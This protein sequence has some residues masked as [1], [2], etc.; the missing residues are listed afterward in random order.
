MAS[1]LLVWAMIVYFIVGYYSHEVSGGSAGIAPLFALLNMVSPLFFFRGNEAR[2]GRIARNV[3]WLYVIVGILQMAR[4]LIPFEDIIGLFIARFNGGPIGGGSSYRGVQMLETEP[5]R[6]SFQILALFILATSL[7]EGWKEKLLVVMVASQII[8][9]GSTTGLLLTGIY[10]V[11]RF[12]EQVLRSPRFLLMFI[13][14]TF[15]IYPSFLENPKTNLL[16]ELYQEEGISGAKTA[17]AA[18]SG[19]RVLGMFNAI[20]TIADNPLGHGP[21]PAFFGG[22]K[23]VVDSDTVKG[24][25][26]RASARPVSSTLTYL[27]VFGWP[28]FLLLLYAV[29][30]TAGRL[31]AVQSVLF[32]GVLSV[33]YSP[34]MSE[35]TLL[36]LLS[37]IYKVNQKPAVAQSLNA[38]HE[39]QARKALIQHD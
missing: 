34:P 4:V 5:A 2:I 18:A 36:L 30:K 37:V 13:T 24:Y 3:F 16:I 32:V 26:T 27:Y 23:V 15:I 6:A 10:L 19:G 39:P 22:V 11:F 21:D 28:M 33:L 7:S 8:L 14:A 38:R 20:D 9:I 35:I 12:S 17:L 25:L 1:V 31:R 29:R